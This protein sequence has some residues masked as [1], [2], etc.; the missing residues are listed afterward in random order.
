[1]K[2][3][4]KHLW[5]ILLSAIVLFVLWMIC[6][7]IGMLVFSSEVKQTSRSPEFVMLMLFTVSLINSAV[8]YFMVQKAKGGF[9]KISAMVFIVMFGVQ[10][11]LSMIEAYAFNYGLKMPLNLL[12]AV[13]T[14]GLI[15]CLLFAPFIT[16]MARDSSSVIT[17]TISAPVSDQELIYKII[18]ILGLGLILYPVIYFLAGYYIAWQFEAVRVF[19]SGSAAIEPFLSI[20]AKNLRSGLVFLSM[21]RGLI[22]VMFGLLVYNGTKLTPINKGILI[23]IIFAL[24]MNSQHLIPNPYFPYEVTNA[25]FIE[26]ASSNFVWGFLLA[27]IWS[28]PT[29]FPKVKPLE[30]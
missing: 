15:F 5:R 25:H 28:M 24:I 9:M 19:W 2:N 4:F 30:S 14:G 16:W 17:E 7:S 6:L 12:L 18:K 21:F 27:F 10:F 1:M 3:F 29:H 22:W 11:F 13:S 23:G 8:L 26:T 20:M